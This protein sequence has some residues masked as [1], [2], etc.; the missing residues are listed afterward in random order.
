M[1]VSL[2]LTMFG[3]TLFFQGCMGPMSP[4]SLPQKVE[5]PAEPPV[6]REFWAPLVAKADQDPDD[7]SVTFLFR[8]ADANLV[9]VATAA[10]GEGKPNEREGE[11]L[12]V[13]VQH[14]GVTNFS[15]GCKEPPSLM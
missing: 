9:R 14:K 4:M 15:V 2:T 7:G 10:C 8:D 3:A 11:V 6:A 13:R 1:C 5:P 12:I